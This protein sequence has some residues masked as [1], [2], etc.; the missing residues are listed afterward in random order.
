MYLC[1][2]GRK[3]IAGLNESSN[4]DQSFTEDRNFLNWL[5]Y[6]WFCT[7]DFHGFSQIACYFVFLNSDLILSTRISTYMEHIQMCE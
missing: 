4:E 1:A 7:E 3:R 6:Y 5:R 2:S